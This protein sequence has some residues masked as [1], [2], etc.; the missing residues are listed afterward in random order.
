MWAAWNYQSGHGERRDRRVALTYWMNRLQN[1]D[2]A[3][4]LFVS[5]NPIRDP[6]PATVFAR[7]SYDHP[8]FDA[9]AIAA[10]ETLPAIQGR[11]RLWFCGSYCG[12]GFHEDGLKSA[13]AVALALGVETP[14]PCDVAAAD[15][16]PTVAAF[17]GRL[18]DA[19]D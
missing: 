3:R 12:W 18:A 17:A 7:F 1:L 19:A 2:P 14:W 8:V 11:R 10:Q 5:M 15:R 6:D 9:E 4:P 16:Q 13:I